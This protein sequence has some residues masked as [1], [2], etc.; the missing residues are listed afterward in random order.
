MSSEDRIVTLIALLRRTSRAMVD[1]ITERMEAAG[2]P[3]SPP[4]HHPVFESLDPE[5]TRLTVLAARAGM[6]H[7]AMGELVRELEDRGL[8]ERV[9]DPSDGRARL[10]RLTGDG[11]DVVR[12]AVRE[13]AA[14]ERRWARRWKDAGL[15]GDLRAALEAALRDEHPPT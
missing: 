4:R 14:I 6:T 12:A 11:R 8:V 3:D 13:I 1:E 7:Q 15:E 10:V 2:F 5:G 9:E